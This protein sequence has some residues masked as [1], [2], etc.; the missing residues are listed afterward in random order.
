MM[1]FRHLFYLARRELRDAVVELY[2]R[3]LRERVAELERD[4]H[5][6]N[7]ALAS[8]ITKVND[9]VNTARGVAA[10]KEGPDRDGPCGAC[11][12]HLDHALENLDGKDKQAFAELT[13][14]IT[15]G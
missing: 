1:S 8:D 3:P 10:C 4:K 7:L 9:V 6:L 13:R 14:I 2:A 15:H 12:E 11:L 5:E